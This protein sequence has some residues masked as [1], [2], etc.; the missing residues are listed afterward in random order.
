MSKL[1]E[2]DY[3]R[4]WKKITLIAITVALFGFLIVFSPYFVRGKVLIWFDGWQQHA[5]FLEYFS[6]NSWLGVVGDFDY[7]I[8]L[9]ADS[10][11]SFAYYMLFDPMIIFYFIFFKLNAAFAYS[12]M[13]AMKLFAIF[14]VMFFYL[15]HKGIRPVV[16]ILGA[17]AYMVCGASIFLVPRHPMFSA[18][19]TFLPLMFWGVENIL[20]GKRPYIFI[21]SVIGCVFTCYYFFYMCAIFTAIY[22][23]VYYCHKEKAEDKKFSFKHF[24]LSMLKVLGWAVIGVMITAVMLLPVFYGMMN[25]ARGSG[26]GV[27]DLS[28]LNILTVFVQSLAV[29]SGPLYSVIGLNIFI[30]LALFHYIGNNKSEYKTFIIIF[31]ICAFLPI[32]GYIMN[33]FNYSNNRWYFVLAFLGIV[34]AA[35]GLESLAQGKGDKNKTFKLIIAF[36]IATLDVAIVY[37]CGVLFLLVNCNFYI[38]LALLLLVACGLIAL[39]IFLFKKIKPSATFRRLFNIKTMLLCTIV[40]SLVF[41]FGY[42]IY[43]SSQYITNAKYESLVTAD[44]QYI[45]SSNADKFYRADFGRV[46][47]HSFNYR[48]TS[49]NNGYKSTF[50][51]NSCS[52]ADIYNFEVV[53]GL[54]AD[55]GTLGIAGFDSRVAYQSLFNVNYYIAQDSLIPYGY[56]KVADTDAIYENSNV[57]SLGTVY[58][59]VVSNKEFNDLAISEKGNLMLEALVLEDESKSNYVYDNVMQDISVT[60]IL[61]NCTITNGRIVAKDNATITY[62]LTG[63]SNKEIYL[64]AKNINFDFETNYRKVDTLVNGLTRAFIYVNVED[65]ELS[66][67]FVDNGSNLYTG[68]NDYLY[69]LGYYT[70]DRVEVTLTLDEGEYTYDEIKFVGYD[71]AEY[72]MNLDNLKAQEQ[73]NLESFNSNRIKGNI[74][75]NDQGFL[76]FSIPYSTGWTAYVDGVEVDLLKANIGFMALDLSA[77]EHTIELKYE[78]PML[79]LGAIISVAGLIALIGS[80]VFIE[81][82]NFKKKKEN[83]E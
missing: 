42:N 60:P 48:N 32:I 3:H 19:I 20:N 8:G 23:I 74:T 46:S 70:E 79:K 56:T 26:K 66:L 59:N 6:N 44:E 14:A 47:Y 30:V 36:L 31:T 52:S 13:V 22:A 27:V 67:D 38:T 57:L 21:A 25:S 28:I 5:T 78:T 83:N 16:A 7:N 15:K 64:D 33:V 58:R 76:F 51:Y 35:Y 11:F 39:S 24:V 4:D 29:S 9:G 2:L 71:M 68:V 53:N 45:A 63:I 69:N 37:G 50:S 81:V 65:R 80:V 61:N 75:L 55:S 40:A 1:L 10:L 72:Q 49:L 17:V 77:G 54:S 62:T 43:Y 18:G 82:K 34:C 12:F 41:P 73:F